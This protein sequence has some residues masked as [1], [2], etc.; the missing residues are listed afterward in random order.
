MTPQSVLIQGAR[1][2]LELNLPYYFENM[3]LEKI[4]KVFKLIDDRPFYNVTAYET[5]DLFFPEWERDLEAKLERDKTELAVAKA[6]A[7]GK[8]RALEAWGSE[9]ERR[10]AIEKQAFERAVRFKK[11]NPERYEKCRAALNAVMR[12]QKD[13]HLALRI[14]KKLEKVT[15]ATTAALVRCGKVIKAYE[16]LKE[17]IGYEAIR[18][19][20]AL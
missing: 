6:D 15:K 14:V 20:K 3:S 10:I 13:Y 1:W 11:S 7:E 18:L 2:E 5:L 19:I 9:L 12:P 17:T 4:R 16:A 8:R